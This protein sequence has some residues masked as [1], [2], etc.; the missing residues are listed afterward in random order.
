MEGI[1]SDGRSWF[2]AIHS[3]SLDD[4]NKGKLGDVRS[5]FPFKK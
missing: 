2:L 5:I 4:Q 1:D 3:N